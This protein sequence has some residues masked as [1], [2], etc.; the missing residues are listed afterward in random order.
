MFINVARKASFAD[1]AKELGMSP[2]YV[3]KRINALEKLLGIKLFHR[4]TRR[5]VISEAGERVYH[6]AQKIIDDAEHLIDDLNAKKQIPRG[7]LRVCSSFGFGRNVVA[8]A[9]A[10]LAEDFPGLQIRFEVFDRLVDVGA[11]GFDLDVRVGDEIAPH[12]IAKKLAENHRILCASPQYVENNGLPKTLSDLSNH[13][14][15]I[16]K[17]RDHPFGLWRLRS[18]AVEDSVKVRGSLSSNHGEIV[19]QW[20]IKG[21]GIIL[22]SIWDVGHHVAEGSLVEILPGW[23]QEANIWA[24]YPAR[25][26]NSAKIRVCIE[27]LQHNLARGWQ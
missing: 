7:T 17:E 15:L 12:H 25:L 26:D 20:A 10:R 8:P 3:S 4:S 2:A 16:I 18:G 9:L 22:R 13:N 23:V 27:G 19:V 6:W 11:E 1:A 24:V 21:H 14:C 5:V